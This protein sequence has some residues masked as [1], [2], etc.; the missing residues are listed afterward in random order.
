MSPRLSPRVIRGLIHGLHAPSLHA[1]QPRRP[2]AA[3]RGAPSAAQRGRPGCAHHAE[4]SAS[5]TVIGEE[6]TRVRLMRSGIGPILETVTIG[7][8]GERLPDS[9]PRVLGGTP[10]ANACRPEGERTWSEVPGTPHPLPHGSPRFGLLAEPWTRSGRGVPAAPRHMRRVTR[11][12]VPS[13]SARRREAGATTLDPAFSRPG[14]SASAARRSCSEPDARKQS[15]PPTQRQRRTRTL[16]RGEGIL[17]ELREVRV[18][19]PPRV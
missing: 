4:M 14:D 12:L 3:A 19:G 2:V 9:S 7:L 15:S 16:S 6:S 13:L 11:D 17:G 10:E 5:P 1:G 18:K 8:A